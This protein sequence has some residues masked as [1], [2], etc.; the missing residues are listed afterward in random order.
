MLEKK[1]TFDSFIR[2]MLVFAMIAAILLLIRYL[3]DV[4]TPF[5]VAW[6]IAYLI[7][8]VVTFVQYKL[9]F[10]YRILSIFITL[11]LAGGLVYGFFALTFPQV[12]TEL[13]HFKESLVKFIQVGANNNSISP[14]VEAFIHEQARLIDLDKIFTQKNIL[15]VVKETVPRVWNVVYQTANLLITLFSSCIAL[16]YLFFILVDYEKLSSGVIRLFPKRNRKFLSSL[17][18]DLQHGMNNYFRGQALIS[19]CV[20]IL[21]SVG[22]VII[23]FPL[24]IPL[25]I[26]IG[27]LSFVPYLHALGL[28][29]TLLFA[30]IKAA[31]TG[32]NFWAVLAGALAV[33][34]IVQ[35]IQDMVLTP[36]IMGSAMGLPPFLILLSL[37]VWGYLLGIIGMIIALPLTTLLISYYQR[38]VTKE[39]NTSEE[40]EA[41]KT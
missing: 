11:A 12:A 22:F 9:H 15:N 26:F 31:D 17:F 8:P 19:V 23:G 29:P 25:G 21:F 18:T 28:V 13:E 24:A 14:K 27:V 40:D 41:N 10:H 38:Y 33:F 36:R 35:I 2:G 3:E 6:F 39:M 34:L 7:Y 16:L 30:L 5:F 20:G 32:Q 37:S 1:I 4:L